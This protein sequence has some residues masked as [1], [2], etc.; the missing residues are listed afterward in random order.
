VAWVRLALVRIA[1]LAVSLLALALGAIPA[2]SAAGAV[3]EPGG[4]INIEM[5]VGGFQV[6]V[7]GGESEGKHYA[8]LYL[9][10]GHQFA[11]Y[12]A[13][14][15]ITD[16]TFQSSFGSFGELDYSFAPKGSTGGECFG[17]TSSKAEFTGTFDFTGQRGYIHIDAPRVAGSYSVAPSPGCQLPLPPGPKPPSARAVPYQ[18][19]VGDGATLTAST[20]A[21]KVKR[22][23][24]SVTVSRGK[25]AGT[26][27]VSAGLAE[28]GPSVSVVRGVQATVPGQAFE[29]DFTAGTATVRPPAPFA[30]TATF[31]RLA[32]GRKPFTGSL[33]ARVLGG[34][35]IHFA[36][37]GFQATLHHGTP[38]EE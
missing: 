27:E 33:R 24:R 21:T 26:A 12:F 30:G 11:Q 4:E 31:T 38:H 19:Y 5:H 17:V 13:P 29:W 37:A 8:I 2:A 16:S 1:L 32:D 28:V 25:T 15:Q 6:G 10:R 34:E 9:S 35:T 22:R 14:A 23:V 36:G 7:F 3:E 18:P 20:L